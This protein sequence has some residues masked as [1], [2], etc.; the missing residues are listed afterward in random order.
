MFV[1]ISELYFGLQKK[2]V[3]YKS[4]LSAR[5][6]LF[7]KFLK[8]Q[9]SCTSLPE[10]CRARSIFQL[11]HQKN[12]CS[13]RAPRGVGATMEWWLRA[14]IQRVGTFLVC[15][16]MS[17]TKH[18]PLECNFLQTLQS[19]DFCAQVWK[20]FFSSRDVAR[21]TFFSSRA[22]KKLCSCRAPRGDASY[23]VS[24]RQILRACLLTLLHQH[25][26]RETFSARVQLFRKLCKVAI[27]SCRKLKT[28]FV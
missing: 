16:K 7:G 1:H 19:S 21:E 5:V 15:K 14:V 3:V 11:A 24:L 8:F 6:Q 4:I 22:K 9:I 23:R 10:T 20:L 18:F 17:R 26:V 2:H 28:F 25:G 27:F 13:C 12:L